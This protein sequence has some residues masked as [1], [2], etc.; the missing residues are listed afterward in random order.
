MT[1]DDKA[2]CLDLSG[3]GWDSGMMFYPNIFEM[4][5]RIY[6]LHNSN[7]FGRDGFGLAVL[8]RD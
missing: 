2:G 8:E 1:R 3:K 7:H 4:D 5:D 6:L